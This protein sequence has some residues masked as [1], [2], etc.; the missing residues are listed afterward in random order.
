MLLD[1]DRGQ[2]DQNGQPDHGEFPQARCVLFLAPDRGNPQGIGNVQRGQNATWSIESV[3][4]RNRP[5]KYVLTRED[6]RPKLLSAW[7]QNVY[8]DGRRLRYH[9]KN[10]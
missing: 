3:N 1:K 5:G 4:D 7:L 2:G 6:S 8:G 9:E 10:G